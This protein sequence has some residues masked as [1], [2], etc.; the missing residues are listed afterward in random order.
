VSG[1]QHAPA[2]L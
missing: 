2:V 1:K